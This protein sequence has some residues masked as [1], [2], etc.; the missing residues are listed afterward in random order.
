ML[1]TIIHPRIF[2][3]TERG[4]EYR[5]VIEVNYDSR[6]SSSRIVATG[7]QHIAIGNFLLTCSKGKE[8]T[9]L[10]RS[11][12]RHTVGRDAQAGV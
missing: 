9:L 11:T 6:F 8:E 1:A 5:Y 12:V 3:P 4:N 2:E 7:P 10:Q